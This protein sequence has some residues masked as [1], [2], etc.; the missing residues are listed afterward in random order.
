MNLRMTKREDASELI[1]TVLIWSVASLLVMRLW[2]TVTGNPKVAIGDWHIAHVT[3]GGML[4]L[5]GM[6]INLIFHGNKSRKM[7]AV[8]FGVGFGL[9]IDEIGKF[10]SSDNDYWFRPAIILIYVTFIVLFMIYRKLNKSNL[11]DSK[12][13][14]YCV[15]T[16]LEEVAEGDLETEEKKQLLKKIDTLIK[17]DGKGNS[18]TLALELRKVV[19]KMET[20]KDR[21]KGKLYWWW[22]KTKIFS[23]KVFKRKLVKYLLA[24]YSVYFA[25]D[26]FIEGVKFLSSPEK[27]KSIVNFYSNY[28]FFGKTDLYMAG[29]KM[30]F[31]TISGGLFLLGWYYFLKKKRVRGVTYFRWGL[32]VNILLASVFKFYFEQFSGV[33]G[34]ALAMG[35]FTL[36]GEYRKEIAG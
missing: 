22:D 18:L 32:L 21:E 6:M 17:M 23:Y 8:V 2:L 16:K 25:I 9:F 12:T 30:I 36:L 28:D 34:L 33:F 1:L 19:E 14:L 29:F 20:K 27:I 11:K 5:T 10:V 13:L 15:L 3:E 24:G 7:S 31:D 35:V 4:M 26:K